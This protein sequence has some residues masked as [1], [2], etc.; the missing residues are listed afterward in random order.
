MG[1]FEKKVNLKEGGSTLQHFRRKRQ[2]GENAMKIK[3]VIIAL[4]FLL[5]AFQ[6]GGIMALYLFPR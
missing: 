4:L 5:T 3:K 6:L 2:K 1:I